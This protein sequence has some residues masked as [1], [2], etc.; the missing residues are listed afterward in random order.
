MAEV[1]RQDFHF[2]FKLASK[3]FVRYFLFFEFW[4]RIGQSKG[5]RKSQ[6]TDLCLGFALLVVFIN[7]VVTSASKGEKP[8]SESE[9][10]NVQKVAG[11]KAVR[12]YLEER[13]I[14][15]QD[16]PK[17]ILI[18]EGLSMCF[19]YVFRGALYND[20]FTKCLTFGYQVEHPRCNLHP[21]AN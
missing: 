5:M 17:A 3:N 20:Q 11:I 1:L 10:K 6:R 15:I 12:K 18:Y 14:D 8:S 13:G 19:M 7:L 4:S 9:Q 2:P 16:I 21:A